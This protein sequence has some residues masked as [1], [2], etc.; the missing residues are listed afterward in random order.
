MLTLENLHDTLELLS[1]NSFGKPQVTDFM[2]DWYWED[3]E[4]MDGDS[5]SLVAKSFYE[6]KKFPTTLDFL[7]FGNQSKSDD[8]FLIMSAVNDSTAEVTISGISEQ[9]LIKVTS[10]RSSIQALRFLV[11]ADRFQISQARKDWEK[12]ISMPADPNAL[13]PAPAKISLTVKENPKSKVLNWR[14]SPDYPDSNFDERASAMMRCI[15]DKKAISLAWISTIDSFPAEKRREV[16]DFAAAHEYPV[17]GATKSRFYQRSISTAKA[18]EGIDEI[19]ERAPRC[20]G[21][22]SVWAK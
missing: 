13:T 15:A 22:G 17:L 3:L 20:A 19:A 6:Q 2:I 18:M 9:A 4:G 12:Q 8:W 1:G 7:E 5:F 11:D 21:A 10:A 14:E 16:Y